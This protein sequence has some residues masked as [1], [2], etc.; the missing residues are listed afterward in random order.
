MINATAASTGG[1]I[2]QGQ[3]TIQFLG[4]SWDVLENDGLLGLLQGKNSLRM[5]K[6]KFDKQ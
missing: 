1:L 3:F 4:P 5:P 2:K 6:Y